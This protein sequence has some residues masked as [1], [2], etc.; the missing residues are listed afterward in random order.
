MKKIIGYVTAINGLLFVLSAACIDSESIIPA[1]MC[2]IT[3]CEICA[4][5]YTANKMRWFNGC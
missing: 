4:A 1:V 3:L 5:I 2:A